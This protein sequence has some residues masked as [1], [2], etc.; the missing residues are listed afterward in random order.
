LTEVGY[1]ADDERQSC[2]KAHNNTRGILGLR[3]SQGN[4]WPPQKDTAPAEHTPHI[5]NKYC[6]C[7]ALMIQKAANCATGARET[8]KPHVQQVFLHGRPCHCHPQPGHQ[9]CPFALVA[10]VITPLPGT[11]LPD[12]TPMDTRYFATLKPAHN[13]DRHKQFQPGRRLLT[14]RLATQHPKQLVHQQPGSYT[15]QNHQKS[16]ELH[17]TTSVPPDTHVAFKQV[18][19][20][21]PEQQQKRLLPTTCYQTR[22][23]NCISEAGCCAWTW[24]HLSDGSQAGTLLPV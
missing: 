19:H 24:N 1:K 5:H 17:L 20:I 10:R 11:S 22:R 16:P 7:N 9:L 4:M 6:A 12:C 8:A 23:T 18:L 13:V 2:E 15:K 3:P 14:A 21:Q